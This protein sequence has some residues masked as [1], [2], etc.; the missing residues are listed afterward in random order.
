MACCV[1]RR[2]NGE[3][4]G[5]HRGTRRTAVSDAMRGMRAAG[6]GA[7]RALPRQPAPSRQGG[8]MP[9]M[10]GTVR[11]PRV[12]GVL[13]ARVGVRGGPRRRIAGGAART[14]G[15]APQG[16][17]R[18]TACRRVRSACWPSR[19]PPPGPD[20]RS[21][22]PTCLRPGL[23]CSAAASTT[24]ARI[25]V[26]LAAELERPAR[27][28]SCCAPP[29]A[30]NARSDERSARPTSSGTFRA[31]GEPPASRAPDRRRLHDG[32]DAGRSRLGAARRGGGGGPRRGGCAGVVTPADGRFAARRCPA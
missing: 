21:A 8:R 6:G 1:G 9:A 5:A 3:R 2:P 27:S 29:P 13:V 20:G 22:S 26:A 19:S 24:A 30:T 17:R 18:T 32:C 16:R 11:L 28:T 7:L 10:R 25:A 4:C 15:R 23:R 31:S 12:H 14:S